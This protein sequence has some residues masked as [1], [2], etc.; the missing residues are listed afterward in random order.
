LNANAP[1]VPNWSTWTE[2]SMT[3]SA[4]TS[5]F[6]RAGSPP[7][8]AIASRIAARSTMAGTPVKSWSRTREGMNG[9]SASVVAPGRHPA[10]VSTSAGSIRPPPAFRSAFSRR[11]LR[12]TGARSRSIRSPS[13]ASRQ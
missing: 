2:W 1:A 9:I 4:G 13:A 10:S 3:R 11:I 8:S 7:S 6:T 5:G 12:V